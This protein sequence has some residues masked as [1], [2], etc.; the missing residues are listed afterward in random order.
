VLTLTPDAVALIRNKDK[1]IFLELP[2]PITNCCFHL[3]EC[4]V[5]R[6]GEPRIARDY[7]KKI[8]RD[9]TVFIPN[10]LPEIPLTIAVNS[11]LG[12]KRLVVDGWS[13]F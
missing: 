5:V 8:I 6:F 3:Q 2:K 1:P 11:F 4:P 9:V 12:I 7:E 13:F 10:R